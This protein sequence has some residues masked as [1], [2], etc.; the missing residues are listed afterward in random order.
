MLPMRRNR[1]AL[2]D[3]KNVE[4]KVNEIQD[5]PDAKRHCGRGVNVA[6]TIKPVPEDPP[7][8]IA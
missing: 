7:P 1:S 5:E 6:V 8:Y 4:V 3:D 2:D